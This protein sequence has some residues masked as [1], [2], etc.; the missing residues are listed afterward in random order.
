MLK[1]GTLK[2]V[3][4]EWEVD[5]SKTVLSILNSFMIEHG[6]NTF[7]G[8]KI[9]SMKPYKNIEKAHRRLD[10]ENSVGEEK[11]IY[12]DLLYALNKWADRYKTEYKEYVIKF[13]F[14]YIKKSQETLR[15]H[16]SVG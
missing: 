16:S 15:T 11:K 1:S 7:E 2:T 6:L 8:S 13:V 3:F 12:E 9:M 14:Y 4:E 10:K 5:M